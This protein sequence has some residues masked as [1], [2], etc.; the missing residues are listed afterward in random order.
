MC[1]ETR[2]VLQEFARRRAF[3][4]E[5]PH[6]LDDIELDVLV[7]QFIKDGGGDKLPMIAGVEVIHLLGHS[8]LELGPIRLLAGLAQVHGVRVTSGGSGGE[9]MDEWVSVL[10]GAVGVVSG[11]A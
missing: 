1:T 7:S 4:L 3:A 5:G 6:R 8:F 2:F 10:E 9:G 11:E